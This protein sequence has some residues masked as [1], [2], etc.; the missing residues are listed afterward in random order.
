MGV[1]KM[2]NKDKLY[3]QIMAELIH[4]ITHPYGNTIELGKKLLRVQELPQGAL[5][6]YK[7]LYKDGEPCSHLGCQSH[8]THPC[9]ECGR[10]TIIEY[11]VRVNE[12][13]VR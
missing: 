4:K 6:K 10:I 12:N 9:E 8:Q 1:K 11:M 13:T 7:I 2:N 3:V 5:P